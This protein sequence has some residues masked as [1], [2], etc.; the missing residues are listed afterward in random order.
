MDAETNQPIEGAV[1]L[2]E[3][4]ITKGPLGLA[5]T[6]S[7]KI[8]E[9]VSDQQGLV[10]IEEGVLNPWV[11]PPRVTVYK[12]GYVAWNNEFIFPDYRERKDFRWIDGVAFRL[13]GFRKEYCRA[14]HVFFV[15]TVSHWGKL[16]IE[17]FRWEELEKEMKK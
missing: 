11:N 2:V 8:V 15:H 10:I 14:D 9:I 13:E 3:W 17:A 6:E 7:Y 1:M 12:R 16:L 4:T 5:Y